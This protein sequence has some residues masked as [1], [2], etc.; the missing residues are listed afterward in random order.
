M[1]VA[2]VPREEGTQ[3][4]GLRAQ[5]QMRGWNSRPEGEDS[6]PSWG[7]NEGSLR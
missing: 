3:T 1:S 6:G 2:P 7:G 4:Q 5:T